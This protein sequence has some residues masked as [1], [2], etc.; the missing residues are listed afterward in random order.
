MFPVIDRYVLLNNLTQVFASM[1]NGQILRCSLITRHF[2][3]AGLQ[4]ITIKFI[5]ASLIIYAASLIKQCTWGNYTPMVVAI[6]IIVIFYDNNN[7]NNSVNKNNNKLCNI[8]DSDNGDNSNDN[9][10]IESTY[11]MLVCV[12]F[13]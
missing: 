7:N 10:D 6:K 12:N 8:I 4:I 2:W 3:L 11:V 9:N 5:C 13:F 1:F